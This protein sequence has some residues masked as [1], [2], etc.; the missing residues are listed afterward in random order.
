MTL[1]PD[2]NQI[3]HSSL[4]GPALPVLAETLRSLFKELGRSQRDFSTHVHWDHTAVSRYLRGERLPPWE[5]VGT[6]LREVETARGGPMSP[7]DRDPI[8]ALHRRALEERNG[9]SALV[10]VLR[11]D[12]QLAEERA[13]R[14]ESELQ[15]LATGRQARDEGWR[16][17]AF[18][19]SLAERGWSEAS[20]T[21]LDR[22]TRQTLACLADPTAELAYR[23][24]GVV[25]A[26]AQSGRTTIGAGVIARALDAGYRLVVVFSGTLNLLRSQTQRR[27][28]EALLASDDA[29][30]QLQ[31]Q[32]PL[33]RL[34][35]EGSDYRSMPSG[36]ALEFEKRNKALPLFAPPNLY[37]TV[38]RLLV[39]KQNVVVLRNLLEDLRRAESTLEEVPALI[40]DFEPSHP[41]LALQGGVSGDKTAAQTRIDLI[42]SEIVN[43]LPRAQLVRFEH[44][45]TC[46]AQTTTRRSESLWD[47]P[48][49]FVV[50]AHPREPHWAWEEPA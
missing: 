32:F 18:T 40:V 17:S 27:L 48:P 34:T 22:V 5:F 19:D 35:S 12:S 37:P 29:D 1:P 43:L 24:T 25:A 44:Q 7:K 9:W 33:L 15:A 3:P 46:A 26:G 20:L 14:A 41:Y 47:G 49:D 21:A 8:A 6:L 30:Q 42:R 10:Q 45:V 13:R 11:Q 4:V 2:H 23:T 28:E 38:P 50:S 39:V 31:S 16:W 36:S